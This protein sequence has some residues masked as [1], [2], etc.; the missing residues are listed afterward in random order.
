LQVGLL[1]IKLQR[2]MR[3]KRLSLQSLKIANGIMKSCL[4][5]HEDLSLDIEEPPG[6]AAVQGLSL[7]PLVCNEG[8]A[9]MSF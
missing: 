2:E 7:I 8:F 1:A 5:G 9:A 3:R 6:R 4:A